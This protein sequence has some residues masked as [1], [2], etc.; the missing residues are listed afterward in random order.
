M[1]SDAKIG[2]LLGLVFIFIIAFIIN[3]LPKLRG[4]SDSNELTEIMMK[5]NP[6]GIGGWERKAD[7][8]LSPP[9][10]MAEQGVEPRPASGAGRAADPPGD[11]GA[12]HG[13]GAGRV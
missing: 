12:S 9:P 8:I 4:E 11:R 2:L 7:E 6:P 3:G 5:N 13:A 10:Q 1:T